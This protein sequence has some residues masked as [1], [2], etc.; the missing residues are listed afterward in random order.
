MGLADVPRL[1]ESASGPPAVAITFDD[2]YRD[3]SEVA[4]PILREIG[5]PA[6]FFICT[7]FLDGDPAVARR[8]RR[9]RSLPPMAWDQV[10]RLQ[11]EGAHIGCHTEGH[12]NLAALSLTNALED[13]RRARARIEAETG[14]PPTLFA[15]PYG[16]PGTYTDALCIGLGRMGFQSLCTSRW[17]HERLPVRT[18]AAPSG[19]VRLRRIRIDPDD[20]ME[21]F[22]HKVMG[23]WAFV[24]W[25][26]DVRGA[27]HWAGMPRAL[28]DAVSG[29]LGSA[30]DSA[31]GEAG[32]GS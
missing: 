16:V 17:G 28:P 3:N 27:L 25:I 12:P 5:C 26:Q 22:E 6:T 15:F 2:G 21:D 11:V 32:G 18:A 7:G 13:V 9:Y 24:R 1:S 4:W 31:R 29:P 14:G 23:D 10:R 30:D 20:T 8:F 19:V